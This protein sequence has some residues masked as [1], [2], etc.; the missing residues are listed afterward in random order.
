[1][2]YIQKQLATIKMYW[3]Q[4]AELDG[5][6]VLTEF[7][8]KTIRIFCGGFFMFSSRVRVVLCV[9]NSVLECF[10]SS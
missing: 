8:V 9:L 5:I 3:L 1:M 2:E 6:K 7:V 4:W 10:I